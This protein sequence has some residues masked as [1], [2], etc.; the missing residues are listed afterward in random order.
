M[1]SK[2]LFQSEQHTAPSRVEA[3]QRNQPAARELADAPGEWCH[4]GD[5]LLVPSVDRLGSQQ[6]L[7]PRQPW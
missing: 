2:C 1:Q 5:S 6:W 3:V 4:I 7:S